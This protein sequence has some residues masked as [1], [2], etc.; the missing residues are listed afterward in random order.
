MALSAR[1]TV[2][3]MPNVE[4]FMLLVNLTEEGT[5][6]QHKA[7]NSLRREA[8]LRFD[9]NRRAP[10]VVETGRLLRDGF[11]LD[12]IAELA[13]A[14]ESLPKTGLAYPIAHDTV[15][16]AAPG[17]TDG[18]A[19]LH[20]Y[21]EYAAA[22]TLDVEAQEFLQ[23]HAETYRSAVSE[24]ETALGDMEWVG[25]L[26]QYFGTGHRSY[27]CVVSQLLPA[28]FTFGLS[29]GTPEGPMAFYVTAPFI[30]P[31]GRLTFA[32][33]QQATASGE[34]ELVRAFLKPVLS[35]GQ[36][37][38]QAFTDMFE[39]GRD[40]YHAMGYREPLDFLEDH[41]VQVIQARLMIRRGEHAAATALMQYDEEAGYRFTR[42]FAAALEDYELHRTD[43]PTF[44]SYFPH[45]MD[46]IR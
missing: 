25:H 38:A 40:T 41:L 45:L 1:P 9:A 13:L 19:R 2:V 37:S 46:S 7:V 24:L 31:D 18:M 12:A 23:S 43:Y 33:A 27:L 4:L 20:R 30:E 44:E 22:F 26:E 34:R 8:W 28:G 15:Q 17:D 5:R 6:Y 16:R 14:A 35:W 36:L 21:L 32:S 10:A 39:R 3:W 29:L 11:W 42:P